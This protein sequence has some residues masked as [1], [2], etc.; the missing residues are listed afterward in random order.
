MTKQYPGQ[1]DLLMVLPDICRPYYLTLTPEQ[2][3]TVKAEIIAAIKYAIDITKIEDWKYAPDKIS[4]DDNGYKPEDQIRQELEV[5]I[6][7]LGLNGKRLSVQPTPTP[8]LLGYDK[9]YDCEISCHHVYSLHIAEPSGPFVPWIIPSTTYPQVVM[10]MRVSLMWEYDSK[11]AYKGGGIL[12]P[13]KAQAS[14]RTAGVKRSARGAKAGP[15][16]AR[17][18]PANK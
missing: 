12:Y 17:R 8:I 18:K 1:Y 6:Y 11:V 10:E 3:R 4:A 16:T 7:D 14:A 13:A 2:Q 5:Q 9:Q 15:R